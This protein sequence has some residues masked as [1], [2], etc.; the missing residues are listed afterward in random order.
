M[1]QFDPKLKHFR[2][3]LR[4]YQTLQLEIV[5]QGAVTFKPMTDWSRL[6]ASPEYLN[7]LY[8][9]HRKKSPASAFFPKDS[10][11]ILRL[12]SPLFLGLG[13]TNEES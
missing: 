8:V 9:L 2:T 1:V 12:H 6:I 10:P 7:Y 13:K 4:N 11:S 5:D 3:V